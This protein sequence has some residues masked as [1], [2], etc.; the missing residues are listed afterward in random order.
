MTE[1]KLDYDLEFCKG[2]VGFVSVKEMTQPDQYD[3]T[4]RASF[5]IQGANKSGDPK[6]EKDSI[7]FSVGTIK[8]DTITAKDVDGNWKEVKKGAVIKFPFKVNGD[9]V[10]V[11][12]SKITV[13][14]E[15]PQQAPKQSNSGDNKVEAPASKSYT[16]K[17]FD[18]TGIKKG[19]LATCVENLLGAKAYDDGD[20]YAETARLVQ[21]LTEDTKAALKSINPELSDYDLGASAGRAVKE[22][23]SHCKTIKSAEAFAMS[24]ISQDVDKLLT[25]IVTGVKQESPSVADYDAP[26]AQNKSG[27]KVEE[28]EIDYDDDIPFAPIG[29][30][31]NNAYIH[32]I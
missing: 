10:N 26:E 29:L 21:K 7:F 11:S 16:K 14:E 23:C 31:Y 18:D 12:R 2:T 20:K 13:V 15:A 22:A 3:N 1:L 6:A 24:A 30:M 19:H 25:E 32:C 5:T 28:P 9:W 17:K 4:H 27:K 8:G